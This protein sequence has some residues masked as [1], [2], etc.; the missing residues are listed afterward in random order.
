MKITQYGHAI[1]ISVLGI[2]AT[3][4]DGLL[5]SVLGGFMIGTGLV[6]ARKSGEDD[7][8]G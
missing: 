8:R 6:L 7:E 5:W 1:I 2:F 4:F 3:S